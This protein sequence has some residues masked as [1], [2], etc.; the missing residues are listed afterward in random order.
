MHKTMPR[1]VYHF[2]DEPLLR[3]AQRL[4]KIYGVKIDIADEALQKERYT[5]VFRLEIPI[6]E[7]LEI[8]NHQKQFVYKIKEDRIVI[9]SRSGK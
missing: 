5:G 7:V 2:R 6:D 3:I 9:R 8:I 1:E 4:K